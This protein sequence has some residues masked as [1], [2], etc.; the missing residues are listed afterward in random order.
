MRILTVSD[1]VETALYDNFQ[2]E[3]FPDIEM[4]LAC[5]DLPKE[6]L[7]FLVTMFNVPLFYV[8]GN[9]DIHLD[10]YNPGGCVNLDE[11]LI[12][13]KGIRIV[14]FQGSHWYNGKPNQYT[15][16]QMRRKIR[17]LRLK[18]WRHKGVDIVITH[19]PPRHIHDQDDPCH[20]GF[21]CFRELIDQYAPSYFLHGHVHLNYVHDAPRTTE[22]NHTKVINSYGHHIF[23][24]DAK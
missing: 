21:E 12:V 11:K 24:I 15:E 7:S 13:H 9:H 22:I 18:L 3:R 14:G 5:G 23:Q 4:V 17:R 16:P 8:K 10:G 2:L 6:Y 19:A 20:R 1:T